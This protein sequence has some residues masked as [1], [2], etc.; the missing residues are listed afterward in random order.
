MQMYEAQDWMA[1]R[2]DQALPFTRWTENDRIAMTRVLL[3]FIEGEYEA[4]MRGLQE[5]IDPDKLRELTHLAD[6]HA[7][8]R[9]EKLD[10]FSGY[11]WWSGCLGGWVGCYWIGPSPV[12]AAVAGVCMLVMTLF[13]LWRTRR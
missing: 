3:F 9:R 1:R 2:A 11:M 4:V 13:F 12:A 7:R 8:N 6:L 10:R 5:G